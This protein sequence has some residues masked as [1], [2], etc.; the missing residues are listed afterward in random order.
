[1]TAVTVVRRVSRVTVAASGPQGPPG[2]AGA[3]S[4]YTHTQ[5]SASAT[6][7]IDHG[8][9]RKVNVTIYDSIGTPVYADVVHGTTSQ[10]TITFPSAITGSAYIS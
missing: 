9:A 5:S 10:T 6:W 7:I 4:S 2:A 8:L 1:M 3:G